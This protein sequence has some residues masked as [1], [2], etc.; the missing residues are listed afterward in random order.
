MQTPPPTARHHFK[1]KH[2]NYVHFLTLNLSSG[3]GGWEDEAVWICDTTPRVVVV[4]LSFISEL[5]THTHTARPVLHMW[6]AW[7]CLNPLDSL[8]L[9]TQA[10]LKEAISPPFTCPLLVSRE[11]GHAILPSMLS[12]VWRSWAGQKPRIAH[13]LSCVITRLIEAHGLNTSWHTYY[14]CNSLLRHTSLAWCTEA[15]IWVKITS[16]P[17]NCWQESD[18]NKIIEFRAVQNKRINMHEIQYHVTCAQLSI[19]PVVWSPERWL[20]RLKIKRKNSLL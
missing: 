2:I 1:I 20:L 15:R 5:C 14:W 13:H 9:G 12:I 4:S 18:V 10:R 8:F 16:D 17:F 11:K 3:S 19:I 7:C 6:Q